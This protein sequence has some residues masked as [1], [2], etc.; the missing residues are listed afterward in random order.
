MK[1][2]IFTIAILT[3]V[4]GFCKAQNLNYNVVF[5]LTS[6][7]TINQQGLLR[8]MKL[9]KDGNPD[10]K[11]EAVLYGQGLSLVTEA[12]SKYSNEI[13]NLIARKDVT[14]KVC[15]LAMKRQNIAKSQ[16]LPGMEIVPDGI[17]EIISKQH[18]GWGYIKIAH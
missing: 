11:L 1:K 17:Y 7:D 18:D 12:G 4:S 16:L 10:A 14:F 5:D 13:S 8:E 3:V 9:I 2:I 15:A 6:K